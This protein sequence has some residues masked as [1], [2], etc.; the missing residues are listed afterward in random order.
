MRAL[1]NTVP[2]VKCE[3]GLCPNLTRGDRTILQSDGTYKVL[4]DPCLA[5][6]RG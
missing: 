5:G 4:C 2:Y 3:G 6:S 1:P